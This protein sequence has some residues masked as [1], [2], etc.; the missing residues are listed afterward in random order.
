MG[1]GGTHPIQRGWSLVD[2]YFLSFE[3]V[4]I[5]VHVRGLLLGGEAG[6]GTSFGGAAAILGQQD[7]RAQPGLRPT[8]FLK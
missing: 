8:V 1:T 3:S 2:Y 5:T 6:I 7:M 4:F